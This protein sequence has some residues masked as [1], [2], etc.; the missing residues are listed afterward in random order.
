[1]I[2]GSADLL[3]YVTC[4]AALLSISMGYLGRAAADLLLQSIV[5]RA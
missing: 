4:K 2:R 3:C 1:M 5:T